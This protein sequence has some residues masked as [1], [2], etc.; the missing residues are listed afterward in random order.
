MVV[1][2]TWAKSMAEFLM[3]SPDTE[4][5]QQ[6]VNKQEIR[7]KV[8]WL[9][10]NL[11][12]EEKNKMDEQILK[13]LLDLPEI[14]NAK[15]VYAYASL[16]GEVDTW[17]L[18]KALWKKQIPVALPRVQGKSLA[19]YIVDKPE[20]LICGSFGIM[21]PGKGCRPAGKA[22]AD[23]P[24]LVPGLAFSRQGERVGYGG[25]YYDC[26]LKQESE[27]LSIGLGYPFQIWENINIE[28]HDQKLCWIVTSQ[29]WIVCDT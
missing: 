18:M 13:T 6:I 23:C 7:E 25:G 24:I 8:K 19:F 12:S 17:G 1:L 16:K 4:N 29:E 5:K 2:Q 20:Q 28:K 15:L 9:R 11:S 26:F 14:L 27:H 10:K 22:D 3:Y 21:E